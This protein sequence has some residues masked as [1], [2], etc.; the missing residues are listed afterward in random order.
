MKKIEKHIKINYDILKEIEILSSRI[1]ILTDNK[2]DTLLAG[3]YKNALSHYI[4]IT[5]L[6][7]RKLYNSAFALI[8]VL[9]ENVVRA[10]YMYTTFSE[11]KIGKLYNNQNW[12]AWKAFPGVKKMCTEFD[13]VHNGESLYGHISEK[14][15]KIMNDYIH[16][17]AN[18]IARNFNEKSGVLD[19]SF[20]EDL[21]L[22]ALQ[23]IC[24]KFK[25][26]ALNIH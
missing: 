24:I 19:S 1:E 9:F 16:S 8:R 15:F 17:G 11:E 14:A 21:I 13:A 10:K 23:S 26:Q 18:Q 7:E 2:R 4:A 25:G 6:I 3:F 5:F 12:G 22:S 20:D